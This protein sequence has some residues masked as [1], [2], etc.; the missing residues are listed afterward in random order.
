[1][2][3]LGC[4]VGQELRSLASA[5]VP[6]ENLYGSDLVPN[7]LSKSYEL[8]NDRDKFKG[9]LLQADIFSDALFDDAFK[10]LEGKFRVLHAGLF[11]H[12]FSRGQQLVVCEKI[13]KLLSEEKGSV[14]LG[15]QVGCLGGGL[16]GVGSGSRTSFLHDEKT[17]AEMWDEVAQSTSTEDHWAVKGEFK[18]RKIDSVEDGKKGG[19]IFVGE[20]IGWLTFSVERI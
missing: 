3:D 12:L 5:G 15:E 11:L 17:F 20:G 6:S 9:K 18:V 4:C 1:M 8:F 7:F 10:G 14:F 19:P 16:R 13:V 2:L